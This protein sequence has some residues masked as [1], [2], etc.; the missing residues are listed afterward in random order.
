[1]RKILFSAFLLSLTFLGAG[2][3]Y[4]VTVET[5]VAG[6][7]IT[8]ETDL[9]QGP[10]HLLDC[11]YE[12]GWL[13][14]CTYNTTVF[15]S[16]FTPFNIKAQMTTVVKPYYTA[17][18]LSY[19]PTGDSVLVR[20]CPNLE[21]SASGAFYLPD[22]VPPGTQ[23]KVL[24]IEFTRYEDVHI[25]INLWFMN[26]SD[27]PYTMPPFGTDDRDPRYG[28]TFFSGDSSNPGKPKPFW[29]NVKGGPGKCGRLGLPN[30]LVNTSSLN[31]V[32]QDT[33]FAYDGLGPGISLKR[34]YNSQN[35]ASGMFGN[36]WTFAYESKIE[37]LCAGAILFKG[38]GAMLI[39]QN[40]LLCYYTGNLNLIKPIVSSH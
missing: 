6:E 16:P 11:H 20:D 2:S 36:G 26:V 39:Y 12:G 29:K 19:N 27:S 38:S 35:T 15:P 37:N 7:T 4:G 17:L 30:Y 34:T 25:V 14:T 13:Y 3:V 18:I 21:I 1:M 9:L 5:T 32:V 24:T 33:D 40:S 31:L 10:P 22:P 28:G 23:V 8:W